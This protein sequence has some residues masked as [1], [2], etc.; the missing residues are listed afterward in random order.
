MFLFIVS[1]FQ[2]CEKPIAQ[3]ECLADEMEV[4]VMPANSF[5]NV[6]PLPAEMEVMWVSVV[7]EL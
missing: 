6:E 1:L 2:A 7:S 4:V 3:V 5:A